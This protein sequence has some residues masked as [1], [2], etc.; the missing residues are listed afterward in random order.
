MLVVHRQRVL[1]PLRPVLHAR[2][3]KDA[4]TMN[5]QDTRVL[6]AIALEATGHWPAEPM[7][8]LKL[9]AWQASRTRLVNAKLVEV[10][11]RGRYVPTGREV[12]R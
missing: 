2:H 5:D 10:D 9:S 6:A 7:A 8:G 11:G 12:A 4:D 3:R 1:A